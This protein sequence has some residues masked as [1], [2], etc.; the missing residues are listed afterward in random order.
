M[1][2]NSIGRPEFCLYN[3][4]L[5][6]GQSGLHS[7]Q[8]HP[9]SFST[10]QLGSTPDPDPAAG[11]S[12]GQLDPLPLRGSHHQS[13][14]E[15]CHVSGGGGAS[16]G[17]PWLARLRHCRRW[18]ASGRVPASAWR[19]DSVVDDAS[20]HR[21]CEVGV[22]RF[23]ASSRSVDADVARDPF[24]RRPAGQR[25]FSLDSRWGTV[26]LYFSKMCNNSRKALDVFS[27]VQ[28][29]LSMRHS[30]SFLCEN[31]QQF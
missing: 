2:P 1:R 26:V 12:F 18:R 5:Y 16:A 20:L 27:N 23:D 3:A 9:F 4:D 21:R 17:N 7:A 28:S 25:T 31:L 22:G 29:W 10:G 30:G 24:P 14:A 6:P 11:G 8:L 13:S 15:R 19:L